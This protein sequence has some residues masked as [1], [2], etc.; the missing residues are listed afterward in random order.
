ME[1][2]VDRMPKEIERKY[3]IREDGREYAEEGFFSLCSS[4]ESLA[5]RVFAQGKP[6]RQGYMPTRK[7]ADLAKELGLEIELHIQ[8]ARLREITGK[9]YLTLKSGG[10][11][12]RDEI[13]HEI[14]EKAFNEYWPYTEG[15]RVQKIR[16]EL[17]YD[18]H[19]VEI[20]L[21]TDRDLIMAEVE[22]LTISEAEELR[23]IGLDVT[24]VEKYKNRNLAK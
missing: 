12:V 22:T 1:Q 14:L 4:I 21:Y 9:F 16:L 19:T 20:D 18:N 7:G 8:E 10:D 23:P 5:E 3:L 13:E 15:R 24:A 11:I 6:V 2:W 17:P